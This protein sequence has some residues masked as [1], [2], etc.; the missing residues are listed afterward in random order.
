MRPLHLILIA[1]FTVLT[2]AIVMNITLTKPAEAETAADVKINQAETTHHA[3]KT[4][5]HQPYSKSEDALKTL[6][7]TQYHITQEDG[8]ERPFNNEYWDNK[9]AGIYVD[10]VSGEPLFSS[11]DKF[12]SGSG[13]PSFT[14][15]ISSSHITQNTDARFGMARTELRSKKGDSHLGHLFDDGPKQTGGKRYCINSA[16]LR[17]IAKADLEKEGYGEYRAL[18]A[19]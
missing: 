15:P 12:D 1:G 6:T 3:A 18:L 10:V 5:A 4:S 7:P 13:W 17:F 16:A 8:T 19:K 11:S 2:G 14:K 9:E